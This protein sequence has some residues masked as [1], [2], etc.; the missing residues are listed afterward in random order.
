[1]PNIKAAVKWTRASEKR[2]LRNAAVKTKLKTLFK[3]ASAPKADDSAVTVAMSALD[4]AA[5]RGIIHKN[6][7]NRKKSRLAKRV[8]S[9]IPA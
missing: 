8:R 2:R 6:A 5:A 7:A 1:M 4:K 3:K 9:K